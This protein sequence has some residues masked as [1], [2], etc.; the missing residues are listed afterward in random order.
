MGSYLNSI[1]PC[2]LYKSEKQ[3]M[4]FVDKTDMLREL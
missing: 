4:Y 3:S 2:A 1:T